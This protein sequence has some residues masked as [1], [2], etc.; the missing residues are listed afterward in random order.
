MNFHQVLLS[1]A[2]QSPLYNSLSNSKPHLPTVAFMGNV[3]EPG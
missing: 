3:T 2:G 1:V